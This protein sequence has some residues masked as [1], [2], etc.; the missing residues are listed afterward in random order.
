MFGQNRQ[1]SD[2]AGRVPWVHTPTRAL[3]LLMLASHSSRPSELVSALAAA[4]GWGAGA[5]AAAGSPPML[6]AADRAAAYDAHRLRKQ[7]TIWRTC[8]AGR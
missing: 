5:G 3:S 7:R 1:I 4:A 6:P 8:Q 2:F